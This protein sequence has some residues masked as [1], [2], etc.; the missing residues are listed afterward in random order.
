MESIL[1]M[2]SKDTDMHRLR[3]CSP[4][5]GGQHQTLTHLFKETCTRVF[6]TELLVIAKHRRQCKCPQKNTD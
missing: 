3:S 1:I 2:S 4:L 5:L 6:I